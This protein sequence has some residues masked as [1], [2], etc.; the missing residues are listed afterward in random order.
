[1]SDNES[2]DHNGS[3]S[4]SDSDDSNTR[5]STEG[6]GPYC[7]NQA[8]REGENEVEEQEEEEE[9]EEQQVIPGQQANVPYLPN[10]LPNPETFFMDLFADFIQVLR[11]RGL[12]SPDFVRTYI[13]GDGVHQNPPRYL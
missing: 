6:Q 12:T 9:Q 2:S 7:F 11:E 1:M 5:S 3:D 10:D 4:D 13:F 8:P